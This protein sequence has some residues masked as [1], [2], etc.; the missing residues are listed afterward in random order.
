[1]SVAL[2]A[3]RRCPFVGRGTDKGI[4]LRIQHGDQSWAQGVAQLCLQQRLT[5]VLAGFVNCGT[6]FLGG[7]GA[8]FCVVR[9]LPRNP[10]PL[11]VTTHSTSRRALSSHWPMGI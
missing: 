1:M 11:S 10:R 6:L 8:L 3:P 4:Y 9:R 2:I 5:A 7:R